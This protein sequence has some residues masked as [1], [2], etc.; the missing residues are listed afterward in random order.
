MQCLYS[1]VVL[2]RANGY[3]GGERPFAQPN[4]NGTVQFISDLRNLNRQIK[5]KPY[6]IAKKQ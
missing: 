5:R 4:K 2:E 3:E 6:T 1:K